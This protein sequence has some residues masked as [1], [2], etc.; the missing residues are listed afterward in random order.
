THNSFTY[1]HFFRIIGQQEQS[2]IGQLTYGVRGLMLDTY[3][4][5]LSW[6]SSLQGAADAK[7]CLSHGTPGDIGT[8]AQKGTL[9]Y[10]SLKYE[11]HRILEFMK[12]N[13]KAVITIILEDYEIGRAHV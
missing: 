3:N 7:V 11:L 2:I 10:Q 4:W 1:P 6:P 9:K 13:P 5:T 8:V 12:V